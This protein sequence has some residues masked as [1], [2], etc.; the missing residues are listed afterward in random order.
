MNRINHFSTSN[1]WKHGWIWIFHNLGFMKTWSIEYFLILDS[2]K[3]ESDLNT[4]E[5]WIHENIIKFECFLD[6]GFTQKHGS[7][8]FSGSDSWK[9]WIRLILQMSNSWKTRSCS[10]FLDL[11]FMKIMIQF[12]LKFKTSNLFLNEFWFVFI[13][14]RARLHWDWWWWWW[15][16]MRLDWKYIWWWW[17]W[18]WWWW[19]HRFSSLSGSF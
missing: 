18:W 13:R 6:L 19:Y 16:T 11:G 5:S 17:W 12:F 2:E 4:S 7:G 9:T 15:M 3:H 14:I 1:S 10:H 8:I